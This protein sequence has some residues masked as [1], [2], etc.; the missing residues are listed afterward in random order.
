MLKYLYEHQC[1]LVE[2]GMDN[3]D[4]GQLLHELM[5][6]QQIDILKYMH[7]KMFGIRYF[8]EQVLYSAIQCQWFEGIKYILQNCEGYG[9]P[10]LN[11]ILN[12]FDDIEI[13]QYCKSHSMMKWNIE[14]NES[15]FD[16]ISKIAE[17]KDSHQFLKLMI[18]DKDFEIPACVDLMKVAK[19][20][21]YREDILQLLH[22]RGFHSEKSMMEA[23]QNNLKVV[24]FFEDKGQN[25]NPIHFS[26]A[27]F[28]FATNYCKDNFIEILSYLLRKK[29]PQSKRLMDFPSI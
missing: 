16:V 19:W 20:F 5:S 17:K 24:K 14:T 28:A 13:L 27:I 25:V 1:P 12:E 8:K 29:C 22:D 18:F 6:L 10:S 7:C 21:D 4:V 26:I 3:E 2:D 11:L 15:F 9:L 23:V